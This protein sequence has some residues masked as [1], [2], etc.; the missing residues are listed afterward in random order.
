MESS[1]ELN[2]IRAFSLPIV[3]VETE[4]PWLA[5]HTRS[6]HEHVLNRELAKRG[7][8]SFLPLRKVTRQWSDR[9]MVIEEPLFRGYLFVQ[10]AMEDR[11]RALSCPGAIRF[12]GT[13][14][15][16]WEVGKNEIEA[17][18]RFIGQ[19]LKV[20]PFPYLREGQRVYIRSGPLKGIEGFIIRKQRHCR[21]VISVEM[22]MQSVSVEVD[23]ACVETL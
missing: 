22:M 8:E 16:P 5:I 6:R 12:V 20:D 11:L 14:G 9:R 19:G 18:H 2:V 1:H 15:S 7:I 21:L 3:P 13:S 4:I 17:L 10:I 23:E